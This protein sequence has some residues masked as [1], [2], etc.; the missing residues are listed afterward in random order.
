[1]AAMTAE[2]NLMGVSVVAALDQMESDI[3]EHGW[4][5]PP[6]LFVIYRDLVDPA[7]MSEGEDAFIL[8]ITSFADAQIAEA[9]TTPAG[10]AGGHLSWFM[11][12]LASVVRTAPPGIVPD[13]VF[14]WALCAE[15]WELAAEASTDDDE[16]DEMV[17]VADAHQI[18]ADPRR[19]EI[20]IIEA[21]DRAGA[22]YALTHRRA[23]GER[24][25]MYLERNTEEICLSGRV[26]DGLRA[27]AEA[28]A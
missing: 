23:T 28:T 18:H 9:F 26:L 10:D 1:M 6:R 2:R 17:K 16:W 8:T 13:N 27:L 22:T 19:V 11:K 20:R 5:Q 12:R 4:D 7:V 21:V 25:L 24:S 15:G 3:D 14:G